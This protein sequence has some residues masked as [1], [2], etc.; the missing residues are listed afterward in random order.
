MML[1]ALA[2]VYWLPADD[3]CSSEILHY[4]TKKINGLEFPSPL[5]LFT[6]AT[7]SYR[8]ESTGFDRATETEL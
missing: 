4:A 1:P 2:T 6:F 5:L 7:H 3:G 8:N